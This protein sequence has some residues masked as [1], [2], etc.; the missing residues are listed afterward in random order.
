[1]SAVARVATGMDPVG[2][3]LHRTGAG[4]A[5][6]EEAD[7]PKGVEAASA[8]TTGRVAVPV[9]MR[10]RRAGP[11]VTGRVVTGGR[12]YSGRRWTWCFIP[13]TKFSRS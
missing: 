9:V 10:A 4:S 13:R 6:L 1:M 5:N 12:R 2:A 3:V 8:G 7:A 11:G